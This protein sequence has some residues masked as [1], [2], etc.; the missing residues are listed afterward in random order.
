[1][2]VMDKTDSI[3]HV[4]IFRLKICSLNSCNLLL[5]CQDT[6]VQFGSF[7]SM[8]LST[9]EFVKRLPS[10]DTLIM[11]YHIPADA[12][13][14]LCRTQYAYAINVRQCETF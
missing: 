5:Q 13:F 3:V 1:M 11:H 10:V 12:A 7:L 2:R 9:E 4:I 6:L 8:Q 14:F